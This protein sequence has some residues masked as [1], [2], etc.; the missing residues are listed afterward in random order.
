[1]TTG[2]E[3]DLGLG[4]STAAFGTVAE[5]EEAPPMVEFRGHDGRSLAV[6]YSRLLSVDHRPVVGLS[7]EFPDHQIM[8]RGRNLR[9]LYE[10]LLWH[11]VTL[12]Q[13]GD[14]DTVSE[15][16]PF[17]D[18]IVIGPVDPDLELSPSAG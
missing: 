8:I 16:D 12:V 13:E 14:L 1:M 10:A 18:R 7:L 2:D 9:P 5:G 11:R 3:F 4:D 15:S 6:P 17:I